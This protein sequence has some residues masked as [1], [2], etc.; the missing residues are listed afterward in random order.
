M[1]SPENDEEKY[2]TSPGARNKGIASPR[3][4]PANK[5]PQHSATVTSR[6]T[7]VILKQKIEEL[8]KK[9][10]RRTRCQK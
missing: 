2:I 6:D 10:E 8:Q 4:Y 3:A 1:A 9:I 5:S 7:T